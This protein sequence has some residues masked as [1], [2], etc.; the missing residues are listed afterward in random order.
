LQSKH[1]LLAVLLK[2]SKSSL[3]SFPKEEDE[4]DWIPIAEKKLKRSKP[5]LESFKDK[6][7]EDDWIPIAEV[8]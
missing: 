2:R 8:L 4:D 3:K 5:S 6:E 7:D 1:Q